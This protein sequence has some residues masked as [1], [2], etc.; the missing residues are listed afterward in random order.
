[1]WI[2]K[3]A[4]VI[5]CALVASCLAQLQDES[6]SL[7]QESVELL[8]SQMVLEDSQAYNS[9]QGDELSTSTQSMFDHDRA[10]ESEAV[11][12]Q[13][14]PSSLKEPHHFDPYSPELPFSLSASLEPLS[15]LYPEVMKQPEKDE[16]AINEGN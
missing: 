1:M 16:N 15:E 11:K 8:H 9:K 6:Q 3:A 10:I 2:Q 13:G 12:V 14:S 4:A 5:A 7:L